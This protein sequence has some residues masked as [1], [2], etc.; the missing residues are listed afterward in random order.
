MTFEPGAKLATVSGT[1]SGADVHRYT[2]AARKGDVV[3]YRFKPSGT[4]RCY[5]D[6]AGPNGALLFDGTMDGHDTTAAAP[7]DGDYTVR[8]FLAPESDP[9]DETCNYSFEFEIEG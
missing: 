2:L 7:A 5:F 4:Y 9:P 6:L 1:L 3:A 8:I